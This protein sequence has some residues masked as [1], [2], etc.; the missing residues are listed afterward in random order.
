MNPAT[1]PF[2][3]VWYPHSGCRWL[4]RGLLSKHTRIATSE[5]VLPYLTHTTD[6]LLRLDRTSQVHKARSLPELNEEFNLLHQSVQTGRRVGVRE[7][8]LGMLQML[9]NRLPGGVHGGPISSGAPEPLVVDLPLLLDAVPD[10][11]II[12][13]VRHPFACFRSLKSRWEMDGDPEHIAASWIAINTA[14]RRSAEAF[15]KANVLTVR[16]EDLCENTRR[17]LERITTWLG[18]ELEPGMLE[19]ETYYGRNQKVDISRLLTE[20]EAARVWAIAESEAERY[21]Y[22]AD[23]VRVTP[24]YTTGNGG[25]EAAL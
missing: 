2:F 8:M 24:A 14:Y 19:S 12:H 15:G 6:M 4:N 3:I 21:S 13:L 10:A 20:D 22:T 7:Y 18:V 23:E 5:F 25:K 16:Y 1:S 9:E 11:R 17:E